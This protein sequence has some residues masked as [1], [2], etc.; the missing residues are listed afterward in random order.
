MIALNTNLLARLLLRDDER[1]HAAVVALL[2]QPRHY[3]A[4]VTVM[5]ELVWVLESADCTPAEVAHALRLLFGLPNFRPLERE[6][7]VSALTGY[8]AGLDFADA[9]HLA[10]S[11]K[12]QQFLTADKS[13]AKRAKRKGLAPPVELV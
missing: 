9:L 11:A 10:L 6:A 4:P 2:E 3:T 12:A 8:E 1:Q 13:V 7:L 5:L